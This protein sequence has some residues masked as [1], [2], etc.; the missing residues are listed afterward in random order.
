MNNQIKSPL[1]VA[2]TQQGEIILHTDAEFQY[3]FT[4]GSLHR[5]LTAEQFHFLHN[6]VLSI[7]LNQS[8][9]YAR[10]LTKETPYTAL[11]IALLGSLTHS[12]FLELRNLLS[13]AALLVTS[14]SRA[15]NHVN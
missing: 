4:F 9:A 12:E 5:L 10:Q 6:S 15:Y 2:R 11:I 3:A 14:L 1:C 8:S 7:D 13:T